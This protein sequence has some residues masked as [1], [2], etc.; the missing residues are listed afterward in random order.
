MGD[1]R[2]NE[3]VGDGSL[4]RLTEVQGPDAGVS[5]WPEDPGCATGWGSEW[6]V[7]RAASRGDLLLSTAP[8]ARFCL[9]LFTAPPRRGIPSAHSRF[10][11]LFSFD[12]SGAG[13]GFLDSASACVPFSHSDSV[14]ELVLKSLS[15]PRRQG[16]GHFLIRKKS[17][18]ALE[19]C[20][21]TFMICFFGFDERS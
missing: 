1:D 20:H 12:A 6:E 13:G 2:E 21:S 14:L 5:S 18:N 15:H 17:G 11:T 3:Y 16:R 4:R 10:L 7:S 9:C 8:F 19:F